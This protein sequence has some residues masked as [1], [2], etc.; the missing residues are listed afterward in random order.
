MKRL[1]KIIS[2]LLIMVFTVGC[3][4]NTDQLTPEKISDEKSDITFATKLINNQIESTNQTDEDLGQNKMKNSSSDTNEKKYYIDTYDF[5][6]KPLD[7]ENTEQIVLLTFDDCV[8]PEPNSYSLE[9][10]RVLQKYEV[11]AIF[12]VNGKHLETEFGRKALKEISD[13]GFE[14]GNHTYSH[15]Y[16]SDLDYEATREEIV[17]VND[18]VEEITGKRPKYFRPGFGIIGDYGLQVVQEENMIWTNWTY[19]YD[20]EEEYQE[21]AALVSIM[22]DNPYLTNGANLL[23]HDRKNTFEALPSIIEG[24]QNKGYRIVVP[25]E[26]TTDY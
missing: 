1:L 24:L 4:K 26:L 18:Q 23:M 10:A 22:T 21:A 3:A 13:L 2:F 14:I 16:L 5:L 9:I 20:W 6:V 25:S 19:G 15:P 12:F 11:G 8:Q 7:P 17:K